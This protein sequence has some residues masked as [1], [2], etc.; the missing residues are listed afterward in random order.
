[1]K[2]INNISKVSI[3]FLV[4]ASC[5]NVALAEPITN[6]DF[7]AGFDSWSTHTDGVAATNDFSITAGGAA[8]IE[9]DFWGVPGDD[10]SPPS[11]EAF[12][13]NTLFQDV[14]F[15]GVAGD[16]F[17]L[18]FDW[19]FGG[20][21]VSGDPANESFFVAFNDGLGNTLG[22][23]GAAGFV[24][25]PT[26]SYGSGTFS[27]VLDGSFLNATGLFLDFQL[28]V[29]VNSLDLTDALGSFVEIDNVLISRQ[30]ASVTEPSVLSILLL[31]GLFGIWQKR[32]SRR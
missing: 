5:S 3:A 19:S 24:L 30:S 32:L 12:F 2:K 13:G 17:S 29:G 10:Q 1:M 23:D 16:V 27:S 20:Q 28:D 18:S 11:N 26:Q 25:D 8:R 14:D 21:G 7:S 15:S 6:G 9:A 22:V 31:G 4:V